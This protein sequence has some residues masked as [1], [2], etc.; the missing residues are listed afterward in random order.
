M[1]FVQCEKSIISVLA[2]AIASVLINPRILMFIPRF[3]NHGLFL[4]FYLNVYPTT[5]QYSTILARVWLL[6]IFKLHS[7]AIA[8]R[9]REQI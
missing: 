5:L 2:A 4:S 7:L 6:R 8:R 3:L 9:F 1:F